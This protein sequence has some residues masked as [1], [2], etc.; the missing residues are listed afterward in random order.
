VRVTWENV[1]VTYEPLSVIA[2]SDPVSCAIY[3]KE[4]GMLHLPGWQQFTRLARRQKK[5]I[6]LP[7]QA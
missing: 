4:N 5:L 1:E 6:R 7:N 2:K 3:A